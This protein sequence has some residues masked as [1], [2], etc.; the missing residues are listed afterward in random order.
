[1]QTFAAL[2]ALTARDAWQLAANGFEAAFTDAA[3]RQRWRNQLDRV[4][5][6]G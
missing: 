5:E 3:Q 1:V 2:P 6:A 4:F